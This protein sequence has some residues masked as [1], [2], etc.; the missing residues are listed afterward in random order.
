M[1]LYNSQVVS[2]SPLRQLFPGDQYQLFNAEQPLTNQRSIAVCI[3]PKEGRDL[4]GLAFEFIFSAAPG[5]F[6]F[7]IQGADTDDP[8][9]YFT[10][11]ATGTVNA[12]TAMPDGTSRARVELK[13]WLA[14]FCSISISA[15]TANPVNVTVNVTAL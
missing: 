15:Q 6:T 11:G 1:P 3:T 9:A 4:P 8:N 5:A 13:P 7:L 2:N 10:E 14:R 12:S